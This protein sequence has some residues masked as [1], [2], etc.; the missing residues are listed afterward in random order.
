MSAIIEPG[1]SVIFMK[2][3]VHAREPLEAIIERKLKEI[4]DEGM[5][6]WGYGGNTCHPSSM[7]QPFAATQAQSGKPIF[8]VMEKMKSNHF[9]EPLRSEEYSTDGK[10]WKPVPSG[11]HVLGSRYALAIK[12]LQQVNLTLPLARSHVAQGPSQGRAG[13][14]YIS[15]H[16]DKACLVLDDDVNV[17]LRPE[18]K[19]ASI[20]LVAELCA[21]YAVFLRNP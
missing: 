4:E 7:V 15:G 11:I 9:A 18:E 1:R 3:G 8:L 20:D 6:F 13:N 21:P 5:A 10:V 19:V 16:V 2:I 17:P 12:N 14:A